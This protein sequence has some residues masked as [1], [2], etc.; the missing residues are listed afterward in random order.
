[1]KTVL[2]CLLVCGAL[3]G[4]GTA[5]GGEAWKA[6]FDARQ[7]GTLLAVTAYC[8]GEKEG[9][10]RYRM[11]ASKKGPSGTSKSVQSGAAV[12]VPGEP[13][14]LSRLSLGIRPGDRYTIRLKLFE[15]GTRVAE[16]ILTYPP[17]Q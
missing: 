1:M 7:S 13:T 8:R 17:D 15:D 3:P 2:I 9:K 14:E 10:I 16:E 5:A 11:E 4:V 6:W 12:A